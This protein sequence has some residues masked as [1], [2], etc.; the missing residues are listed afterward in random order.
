MK[1]TKFI[2][3]FAVLVFAIALSTF[4]YDM[5][6]DTQPDIVAFRSGEGVVTTPPTSFTD[7][8][9]KPRKATGV[10][11]VALIVTL[12]VLFPFVA[13]LFAKNTDTTGNITIKRPWL[14]LTGAS[15]SAFWVGF[16]PSIAA[17][18]LQVI[19]SAIIM[20]EVISD[21]ASAPQS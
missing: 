16:S 13:P 15:L 7:F 8:L 21:P 1:S 4:L 11:P 10:I 18:T 12:L 20:K 9:L 3:A 5:K 6:T 14:L 2:K 17:R 19:I